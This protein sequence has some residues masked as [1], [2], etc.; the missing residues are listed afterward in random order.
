MLSELS[1]LSRP[2]YSRAKSKYELYNLYIILEHTLTSIQL[3]KGGKA[4]P[5]PGGKSLT[6][7]KTI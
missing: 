6:I 3:G 7:D 4:V 2:I 1:V 5:W